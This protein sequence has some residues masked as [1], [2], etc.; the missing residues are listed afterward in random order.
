V[1]ICPRCQVTLDK[2]KTPCGIVY[3]C[4]Q[5][6]GRAAALAV[7]RTAGATAPFLKQVWM[8]ARDSPALSPLRCPHCN[9]AISA[10]T[11]RWGDHELDLDVCAPCSAVWF[12]GGELG[13]VPTTPRAVA[14][15]PLSE[16][17]REQMALL[18]I[19]A[20]KEK[21]L[22]NP[23]A[24]VAPPEGWQWLPGILG[25]PV[26][27]ESPEKKS[28][29][30]ATWSVVAIAAVVFAV[31]QSDLEGFVRQWGFIPNEWHRHGGLT[32]FTSFFIH[33]GLFHLVANMY[34]LLIFGDNVEDDLG[35]ALFVLLL[36][37]G[38]VLGDAMHALF[39]PRGLLPC[40]GA[41]GGICA[42]LGYYGIMF[43]RAKVGILLRWLIWISL[44]AIAW[45]IFYLAIQ[46][47][48]ALM[49]AGGHGRVSCLAH[50]GGLSAG[51][52]AAMAARMMRSRSPEFG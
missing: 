9:R 47:V 1:A 4:R 17:A 7:L 28:R 27:Y 32:L 11:A 38:S 15:P 35:P 33:A 43:P 46:F 41:S 10:V 22:D 13:A 42:L 3:A 23:A 50:L 52:V 36:F 14:P 44:P 12:D 40:V 45:V 21:A 6:H 2:R 51:I 19:Q 25:L 24:G 31:S 37:G 16:D 20:D 39:D 34:F 48:G 26:E 5:C 8:E 49:Q 30:W 29:P 18:Q